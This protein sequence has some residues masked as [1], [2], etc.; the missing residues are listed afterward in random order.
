[1]K[2]HNPTDTKLTAKHKALLLE[3][4]NQFILKGSLLIETEEESAECEELIALLTP[5]EEE[6]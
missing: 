6:V 2:Q 3:A 4:L 5:T 1:M